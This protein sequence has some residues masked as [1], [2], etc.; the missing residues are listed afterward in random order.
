MVLLQDVHLT[1]ESRAGAVNI[2]RGISLTIATGESI[3]IVGPSGSGKS[4]ILAVT[5]GLERVS[6]GR[7][8]V[9][10]TDFKG[11]SE[12]EL[13]LFRRDHIGIVFQA[14]HLITSMTALENIAIP[15]ELSGSHDAFQKARDKLALVGLE[16]RADHYPAQLSGGE[17]QRVA[18]ARAF[19]TEP[20]LIMA[21]EPTGNLDTA[22]S[23]KVI[24]LIFEIRARNDTTLLLITHDPSIADRCDR[25]VHVNDGIIQMQVNTV[26]T[27]AV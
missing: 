14:F 25:V 6:S 10:G 12:D 4:T 27:A 11:L 15:L 21:D 7:I 17:Q 2:L 22:M 26:Q 16:N 18:I 23:S 20:A 24:D 8:A 13:A 9:A 3:G 19:A 1:L 5:A